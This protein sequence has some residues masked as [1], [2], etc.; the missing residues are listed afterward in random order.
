M[1]NGREGEG[2]GGGGGRVRGKKRRVGGG[3]KRHERF[4]FKF[5]YNMIKREIE[6]NI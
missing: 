6:S 2:G 4:W 1:L 5:F 3:I